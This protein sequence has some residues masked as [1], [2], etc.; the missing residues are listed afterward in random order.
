MTVKDLPLLNASLN[1][2]AGILLFCGWRAIKAKRIEM[3]KR[4]MI[5]AFITSIVFL[6]SYVTY[7]YLK[8]GMVTHYQKEGLSRVVYFFILL[9]HTPLAVL[10]V[11]F[12]V[13][14]ISTGLKRRDATHVR[15]TRR[16][17]PTWIYVSITGVLIYLMLYVF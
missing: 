4:F 16:L 3:H 9:T 14:A 10:I 12:C 13:A 1:A 17:F 2:L 7:H 5:A 6:C 8:H 15:I 11:P